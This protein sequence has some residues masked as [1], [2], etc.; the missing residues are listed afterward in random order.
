M[1]TN[2]DPIALEE[3]TKKLRE[4]YAIIELETVA[5][6]KG[7]RQMK[8]TEVS[9]QTGMTPLEERED[10]KTTGGGCTKNTHSKSS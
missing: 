4:T 3:G 8:R 1:G 5:R 9:G 6:A 7:V 2:T 10:L